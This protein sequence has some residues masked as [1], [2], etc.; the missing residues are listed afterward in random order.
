ML[1]LLDAPLGLLECRGLLSN[2]LVAENDIVGE[3]NLGVLL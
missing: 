3:G 2:Q 1:Q